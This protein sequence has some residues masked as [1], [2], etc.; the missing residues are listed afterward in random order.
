MRGLLLLVPVVLAGVLFVAARDLLF[1]DADVTR[2]K[3]ADV[4]SERLLAGGAVVGYADAKETHA[5]LGIPYAAP[6]TGDRRWRAPAAAPAWSET[7]DALS[8]PPVCPQ[9]SSDIGGVRSEAPDGFAGDED[10]LYLN[11]WA[12]RAE[13]DEVPE[14]QGRWPVMVWIHGG[15]NLRGTGAASMYDGAQIAGR[16]QVVVV[17][18]NYRLGPLGFFSHPALRRGARDAGEASGNFALLDV[19]HALEWVQQN[20]SEFGGDPGNVTIF[21]ESA[22][23]M[24]V[25]ALLLAPPAEGLFHRAVSQSGGTEGVTRDEA[26]APF[27]PD[28]VRGD[29]RP[30][31]AG[32]VGGHLH[33]SAEIVVDLLVEKGVVPDRDAARAYAAGLSDD[34]V[35][36]LLRGA[37]ARELMD[38]AR[39]PDQPEEIRVPTMIRD[40]VFLPEGDWLGAFAAGRFHRVPVVV[41]S[42]RDEYRLYLSQ[43]PRHTVRRFKL[44]Y[45]IRDP[46]DYARRGRYASDLWKVRAVDDPAPGDARRGPR[47]GLRLPFRL[48]RGADAARHGPRPTRRGRSR[49]RAALPLL[50]LRHRRSDPEPDPLRGR[51]PWPAASPGDADA[52]V[53]GR[54]RPHRP[55]PGG[56]AAATCPNGVPGPKP[57]T[58]G[59]G[60]GRC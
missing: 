32:R 59:T 35:V 26:E 52:G 31:A 40:G 56:G 7:L 54:V 60:Q 53:L 21:G 45:R 5:W 9:L 41:G 33:S 11:V 25:L 29:L 15:A 55:T 28:V 16:E 14:G 58:A 13:P 2:P 4:S 3:I 47:R 44:L 30:A 50:Q 22:G 38:V 27:V 37:T 57:V 36:E 48:G 51:R 19:I 17:T 42:N 46:E 8:R 34:D 49:L 20:I 24:N 6:P 1:I 43:D 18:L 23:G 39:D 10:C 12:P